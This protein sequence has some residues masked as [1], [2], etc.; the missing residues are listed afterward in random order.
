MLSDREERI[1]HEPT[2]ARA[3][4]RASR[5]QGARSTCKDTMSSNVDV[6]SG[7]SPRAFPVSSASPRPECRLRSSPQPRTEDATPDGSD[8]DRALEQ[9]V[10]ARLQERLLYLGWR[11]YRIPRD[12]A[13]DL[14]QAALLTYL[15][16]RDRYPNLDEH[17]RILVGIFRNKC[18]E[19]IDRHVRQEKK[20]RA[21]HDS[22]RR[23]DAGT[24]VV[25]PNPSADDGVVEEIV[26]REEESLILEA[27]SALRPKAREMFRL[28][29]EEG[30]SRKELIERYG[31]NKNTLDSRLHT[32]RKELRKLLEQRGIRV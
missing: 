9:T 24:S 15:Q 11:R 30:A 4:T 1:V 25:A 28:I 23:G 20:R 21:L 6:E 7:P 18:R 13:E 16:V 19:H 2:P 31:L 5:A 14:F 29:V 12:L 10:T 27:L 22:V 26:R 17:P 32:Y 3:S 8:M